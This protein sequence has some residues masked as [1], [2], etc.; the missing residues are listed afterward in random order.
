V[1]I[2]QR[3]QNQQTNTDSGNDIDQKLDAS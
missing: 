2:L 3:A 1:R